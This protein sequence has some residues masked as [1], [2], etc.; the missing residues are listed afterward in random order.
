[1]DTLKEERTSQYSGGI[2]HKT[3][4]ELTYNANHIESSGLTHEQTRY[5]FETNTI[6]VENK[7]LNVDDVIETTQYFRGID[8]IIDNAKATLTEK[9]RDC[10]LSIEC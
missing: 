6:G 7:V 4:I 5:I 1:M 2:F 8:M 10:V 3:Q 9:F